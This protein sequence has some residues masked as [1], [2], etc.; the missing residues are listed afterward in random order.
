M[1]K[2]NLTGGGT[3]EAENSEDF[4]K[5][6]NELS[7]FGFRYNIDL[8]MKDTAIRCNQMNS[9]EIRTEDCDVFL[10]DLIEHGF[11]GVEE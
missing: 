7:I 9:C 2:Y 8:F 6:L 10:E 1:K 4:V 5:Q 11:V 3:I